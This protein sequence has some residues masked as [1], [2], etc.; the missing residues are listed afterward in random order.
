MGEG[1][2]EKDLAGNVPS[3]KKCFF[4]YYENILILE[5]KW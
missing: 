3:K 2:T 5:R 4:F 1:F